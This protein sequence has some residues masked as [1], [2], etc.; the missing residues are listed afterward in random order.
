MRRRVIILFC[1]FTACIVLLSGCINVVDATPHSG[2][3]LS[4]TDN[5]NL[6][7]KVDLEKNGAPLD[8]ISSIVSKDN[9]TLTHACRLKPENSAEIITLKFTGSNIRKLSDD[10]YSI[11]Y[12]I[13][14]SIPMKVAATSASESSNRN[15]M[16]G[17][18]YCEAGS[19]SS[20]SVKSG[21]PA[22]IYE[23]NAYKVKLTVTVQK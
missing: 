19:S 13:G 6:L 10:S 15:L 20:I 1:C 7:V 11:D 21:Q 9:I 23:S 16:G 18:Q 5:V 14:M 2:S 22:Y 8:S 17:V 4:K 3:K 12:K